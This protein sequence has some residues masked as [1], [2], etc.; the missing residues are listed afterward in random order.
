MQKLIV[1]LFVSLLCMTG[2]LAPV[3]AATIPVPAA[4][5]LEAKSYLLKDF[6]SG[7][8]L[9]EKN[10]DERV[11][12]ASIT[13]LMTAYVI[14]KSLRD[15]QI[16]LDDQVL[17]SEEAWRTGG[18]KMFIE[19]NT[20]VR[21]EDLLKGMIIQSGN[22]SSI[23]LAEHV[24]GSEQTFASVM[25]TEAESL[26]MSGTHFVNSTGWPHPDH[27]TTARDIA[28]LGEAIIREFPEEY[29][30]YAEKEFVFNGI[31]QFNRNKLLWRDES[32]DGLK[33]GHTESA[34]YCL[35]ASAKRENMRLTSVIMGASSENTRATQ[36]QALLNYGF[37]FFETHK[38]YSAGQSLAE[39][40]IWKGEQK[41]MPVGLSQDF[42]VSIPRGQYDALKA[43]LDVEAEIEAPVQ[44]GQ[45]VG[46]VKVTLQDETI[47]QT[48]LVALTE[49]PGGGLIRY[50]TDS[51]LQLVQRA[52]D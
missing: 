20:R 21:L 47:K 23:A 10:A 29:K 19:V 32:V 11:E 42:Y 37:R 52:F 26:G 1:N 28:T 40:R 39:H 8:V 25:N 31:T 48:S 5:E 44:Q 2:A 51:I 17:I 41:N 6:D 38:L 35:I 13:K 15:S 3:I 36:S 43:S 4:P 9:A 49:I 24:A 16:S 33:T 14:Y 7:Q 50:V 12:P 22:D 18:S 34:G 45:E 30:R 46:Q 27:Y